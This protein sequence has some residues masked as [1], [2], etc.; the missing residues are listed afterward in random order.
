LR[1]GE[2]FDFATAIGW[3]SGT[4]R[5]VN[6]AARM[7]VCAF[8]TLLGLL[9]AGE[10]RAGAESASSGDVASTVEGQPAPEETPSEPTPTEPTPTEPTPSEPTPTEPTPTEPTPSEPTPTEP[11][12]TEPTPTEPTPTEP[13][14]E[15]PSGA[16]ADPPAAPE[17]TPISEAPAVAPPPGDLAS[18]PP[19]PDAGTVPAEVETAVG[20]RGESIVTIRR[21]VSAPRFPS[22]LPSPGGGDRLATQNGSR[23]EPRNERP[24]AAE[25]AGHAPLLPAPPFGPGAPADLYVGAGGMGGGSSG[26]FFPLVLAVLVAL[27]VAVAQRPGGLVPVTLARPRCT[28]LL[29]CLERPD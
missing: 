4:S 26:G 7:A 2:I 9:L 28:A 17:P 24:Q 29:L 23:S 18:K 25:S 3:P 22:L 1:S 21:S 13:T 14:T 19:D 15:A 16:P 11:T 8:A 20:S 5:K 27:F 6:Y 10:A 12:P